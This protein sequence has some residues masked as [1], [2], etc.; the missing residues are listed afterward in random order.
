MVERRGRPPEKAASKVKQYRKEPVRWLEDTFGIELWEKQEEILNSI[1]QNE[2]SACKS[3][4]GSGKSYTAAV[5]IITFVHLFPHSI[6]VST[7]PSYR[8]L[9]N[10]WGT[11]HELY[12]MAKAPLG[13]ELLKHEM[14]CAPNHYAIGFTTNLPS[15]LQG[16]HAPHMLIVE[17]ESA[18][19]DKEIHDRLIDGLMIGDDCH[20]LCIGN[21]LSPEG[22]FYDMFEDPKFEKFT[23]SA[24]DT[25]NVKAGEETIPGLVTQKWIDRKRDEAGEDSPIWKAQVLGEFPETSEDTLIPLSWVREARERWYEVEPKGTPVYGLDPSGGG[26]DEAALCTRTDSYVHPMKAWQGLESPQLVRNTKNNTLSNC[27]VYV[28]VIGVGWGVNGELKNQNVQAIGVNVKNTAEE[29]ERFKNSRAELYWKVR[30]A[31]DPD[32]EDPLALPPDDKLEAQLT[33]IKYKTDSKGRIQIES[34]KD[35]RKRGLKSPDRSDALV[36]TMKDHGAGVRPVEVNVR[37]L[38]R[39]QRDAPFGYKSW[40]DYN[41]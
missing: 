29:D 25:P 24:F 3:C 37:S 33:S 34:K 8:Q 12:E 13:S 14:R 31:L 2:F 22:F 39:L 16:I 40:H 21:P 32:Q 17:D 7:A 19:I 36:L 41:Y 6:A 23:I 35:M 20:M 15:R 27:L 4:F 30:D 5:A 9:E 1:F 10:I 11:I 26:V 28:D 38:D 18:G